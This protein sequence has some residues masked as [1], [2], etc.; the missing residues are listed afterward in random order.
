VRARTP[1]L[2]A[3]L[4]ALPAAVALADEVP[5]PVADRDDV[6]GEVD[7][8]R[9]RASHNRVSDRLVHVIDLHGP[10][11]PRTLLR[12][13][14][15][16]GSVCVNLWTTRTPGSSPPNYDVCAT[17]E[18]RGRRWQASVAR[19]ASDGTVARVASARVAQPSPTR[20]EL[21]VDPDAV[22]RPRAYR[23]TVQTAWFGTGC[24]ATTGCEDFA[25]DRPDWVRTA[26]GRPRAR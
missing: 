9:A 16:P 25:P 4:C 22:R 13:D 18:R 19:H 2:I 26:L 21:R 5:Q 17:S 12:S 3:C 20:L 11:T 15:P 23:W 24:P 1:A 10:I 7:L 6:A 14:G 8:A